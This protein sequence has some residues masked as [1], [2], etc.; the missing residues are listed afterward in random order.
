MSRRPIWTSLCYRKIC[1]PTGTRT[2]CW[3][4]GS[5]TGSFASTRW[6]CCAS[7]W[8]TWGASATP[9]W[10]GLPPVSAEPLRESAQRV[11]VKAYLAE[12]NTCD[13]VRQYGRYRSLLRDELGREPSSRIKGL[14][15]A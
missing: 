11:L 6:S 3:K 4:S 15:D 5:G 13:A 8:L 10:R 9:R 14:V 1:S 7:D 2:R 12:G